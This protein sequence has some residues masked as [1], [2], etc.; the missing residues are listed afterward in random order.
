MD[1][2]LAKSIFPTRELELIRAPKTEVKWYWAL[3]LI[4]GNGT[5]FGFSMQGPDTNVLQEKLAF[6]WSR[7]AQ[8]KTTQYYTKSIETF[9]YS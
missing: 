7:E 3:V 2:R 5:K 8:M 4:K 9:Y 6:L 1:A